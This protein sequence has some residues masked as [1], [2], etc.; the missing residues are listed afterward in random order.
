MEDL[1]GWYDV[2]QTAT[3]LLNYYVDQLKTAQS[4]IVSLCPSL[5]Q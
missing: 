4:E 1:N 5:G 2:S 3:S